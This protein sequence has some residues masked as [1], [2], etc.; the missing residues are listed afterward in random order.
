MKHVETILANRQAGLGEEECGPDNCMIDVDS[1]DELG[2]S[3]SSFNRLVIALADVL[4]LNA[5]IQH[6]S[7]ILTSHLEV[8]ALSSEALNNLI[9][10]TGADGGAI[11]IEKGGELTVKAA[12]AILEPSLLEKNE[13]VLLAMR[14]HERQI[15]RFPDDVAIDGIIA[16]FQPNELFVEPILYKNTLLGI[17]ILGK[18]APFPAPMLSTLPVFN[19]ELSLA[20][21]NAVTHEQM[22][23][24]AAIDPYPWSIRMA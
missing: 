8:D 3:A 12:V 1:E 7:T 19:Q 17:L 2:E 23:H 5:E 22:T 15:I 16:D 13:R 10:F 6:F 4:A 14:T 21:R 24:F 9:R 20:L 11:L 18:S